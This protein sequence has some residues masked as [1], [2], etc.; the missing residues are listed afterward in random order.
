MC[1]YCFSTGK[2]GFKVARFFKV[3]IWVLLSLSFVAYGA[4]TVLPP[5]V[6]YKIISDEHKRNIK[7]TV[8][9]SINK[10]VD[11]TTLTLI[12]KDIKALDNTPVERTFIGYRLDGQNGMYWATTNYDPDLV[13]RFIALTT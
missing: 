4:E 9:V 1:C 5:D 10:R 6:S 8:E 7:R 12:A 13:I 11:E 2:R 3:F